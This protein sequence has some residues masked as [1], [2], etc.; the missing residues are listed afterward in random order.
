MDTNEN[1]PA[2]PPMMTPP[3][4]VDALPPKA[5]VWPMV[6]GVIAIVVASLGLAGSCCG[7][8]SPFIS[9]FFIDMAADSGSA[10][11]EQIAMMRASQPPVVWMLFASLIGLGLSVLLLL[12]GIAIARR[13]AN[14]ATLCKVWS[15]INSPWAA[16][17]FIIG[18]YFQLIVPQDSQ[19]M[20]SAF[21][22]LGLAFGACITLVV[23][24][25]FPLFMLIWFAKATI[26]DE[27]AAWEAESRAMI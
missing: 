15:W 19:Q 11:P 4:E 2:E 8:F 10:P 3:S 14:G 9:G 13:R 16:I 25:A 12:G 6:I 24:I 27:I 7:M 22:Y 23:G 20:G 5:S 1:N 17:A 26:K 18:A 21:Q